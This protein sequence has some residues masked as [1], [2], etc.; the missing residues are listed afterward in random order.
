MITNLPAH[1]LQIFP[2]FNDPYRKCFLKNIRA[3][4]QTIFMIH[5]QNVHCFPCCSS[6]FFCK[7]SQTL[8]NHD[9]HL[10]ITVFTTISIFYYD[11]IFIRL[12]LQQTPLP[13]TETSS[14]EIPS[15]RSGTH[16]IH[17]TIW[18]YN[19]VYTSSQKFTEEQSWISQI[20]QRAISIWK[21]HR[22]HCQRKAKTK[23][24]QAKY[25]IFHNRVPWSN[26]IHFQQFADTFNLFASDRFH[27]QSKR[28]DAV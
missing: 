15:H 6:H 2:K 26:C 9:I 27:Y 24:F 11:V 20:P 22:H 16:F 5:S 10:T 1:L 21:I 8:P 23:E 4:D 3:S 19:I 18:K 14:F 17:S 12:S 13:E 28:H 7:H 25:N